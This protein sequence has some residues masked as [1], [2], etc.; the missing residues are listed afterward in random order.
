MSTSNSGYDILAG[1]PGHLTPDQETDLERFKQNLSSAG[2]YKPGDEST[3]PSHDDAVLL[4]FL[5]ARK[6]DVQ[7]AQKQFSDAEAWRKEN[8][9][10][11]LYANFDPEEFES[12]KRFYPRWTGRRDKQGVPV[13]VYRLAALS[14]P[15]LKELQAVPQE[16][17]RQ[18]ITALWE[19]MTRFTTPL[20]TYLPH[21]GDPPVPIV[22][23]NSIIDFADCSIG[24]LWSLRSHLQQA[25]TMATANY[26]ETLHTVAVV[27]APSYFGTVWGWI[28]NWFDEGTRN[29]IHV[30]GSDPG[31]TLLKLIDVENLPK[32]YGGQLD[33][34]FEDEPNLDE[35]ARKIIGDSVPKGPCLFVDGKVVI[36]ERTK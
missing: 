24:T 14:G 17:R 20:C 12:A 27:N 34:K 7:K 15:V 36:P 8:D 4:R 19:F 23:V 16:R 35:D 28:K 31:P 6:F 26:P 2:L 10:E 11:N 3:P 33:F 22:A 1:H 9:I 32:I 18:R 13:Y 30:L 21:P 5:R 29:K 25:S